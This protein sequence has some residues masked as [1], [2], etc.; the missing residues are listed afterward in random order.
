MGYHHGTG[1]AQC[2]HLAVTCNITVAIVRTIEI[3]AC[4]LYQIT[5]NQSWGFVI[6]ISGEYDTD[7]IFWL[8]L[9]AISCVPWLIY[10]SHRTEGH[11]SNFLT[12]F[13]HNS[14][15]NS[16]LYVQKNNY[17]P[18]S[19]VELAQCWYHCGRLAYCRDHV[20]MTWHN[21]YNYHLRLLSIWN[22]VLSDLHVP[23][24]KHVVSLDVIILGIPNQLRVIELI[25]CNSYNV[26]VPQSLV[27][28]TRSLRT[29]RAFGIILCEISIKISK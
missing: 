1:R 20:I 3:L 23:N 8:V 16:K 7:R 29:A 6:W 14:Q 25:W 2:W 12:A 19:P 10:R 21:Y 9:D 18:N 22:L 27:I 4:L 15:S 26:L 11:G 17:V 13:T 5:Q 28:R 24:L